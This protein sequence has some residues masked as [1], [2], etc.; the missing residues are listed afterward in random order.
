LWGAATP[1]NETAAVGSIHISDLNLDAGT[2]IL[3]KFRSDWAE[4]HTQS[5]ENARL[6]EV[7]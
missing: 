3:E 6:A 2:E 5:E 7:K 1:N 4:L